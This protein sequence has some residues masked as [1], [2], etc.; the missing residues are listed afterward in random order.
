MPTESGGLQ[1]RRWNALG[2]RRRATEACFLR[3]LRAK[4]AGKNMRG[5]LYGL[6]VVGFLRSVWLL[7]G[8]CLAECGPD[9]PCTPQFEPL[10]ASLAVAEAGLAVVFIAAAACPEAHLGVVWSALV[11]LV[12]RAVVDFYGAL[13]LAPTPAMVHLADMVCTLAL[14][15]VWLRAIPETLRLARGAE[16]SAAAENRGAENRAPR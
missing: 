3:N 14:L 6:V 4:P 11:V 12:G 8:C 1:D 7:F 9:V 15:S 10:G 13:T 16:P 2:I 5:V